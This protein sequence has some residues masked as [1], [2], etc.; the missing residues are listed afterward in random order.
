MGGQRKL[1]IKSH[2]KRRT[3][4]FYFNFHE[5]LIIRTNFGIRNAMNIRFLCVINSYTYSTVLAQAGYCLRTRNVCW[6]RKVGGY[7]TCIAFKLKEIYVMYEVW[8]K[9]NRYFQSSWVTYLRFSHFFL[10]CWC[11]SEISNE[12]FLRYSII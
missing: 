11:I 10:L 4:A 9:N 2:K 6:W 3:I 8:S 1:F 7:N 12:S 5:S